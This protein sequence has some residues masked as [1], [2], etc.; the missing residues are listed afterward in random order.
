VDTR[1]IATGVTTE[2]HRWPVKSMAG[3][4]VAALRVD[5]R[6]AGGDRTYAVTHHHKGRERLLTAREAPRLLAWR[7][8][9]VG[10]D[11]HPERPPTAQLTAPDGAVYDWDDAGLGAALS[12]DLGRE[13]G[14]RREPWGQQ[15]LGETLL[16]TTSATLAAVEAELGRPLDLRRFRTNVHLHLDAPAYAENGWEG[17]R[18]IVGDLELQ[19][20][21]PCVRCVIPTR[22][23]DSQAKW[24][25]LL[26]HLSREHGGIFGI[27][28]R[29]LGS[30]TIRRNDGVRVRTAEKLPSST[31][32]ENK[33]YEG[34]VHDRSGSPLSG[35]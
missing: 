7:A 1:V 30:A 27:N 20:L 35:E 6:G 19:L 3:E 26:K 24:A 33:Y 29:P 34:H 23:P 31:I 16:V 12:Q 8:S 5:Q 32:V 9:Y 11:V 10:A 15:D 21:H 14:L 4:P 2:L 17:L 13:V 28:A 25:D 18:M 22:D